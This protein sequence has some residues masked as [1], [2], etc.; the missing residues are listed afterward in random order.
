MDPN[1]NIWLNLIIQIILIF[2]NALFAATEIAVISL[3]KNKLKK[4]ADDGE[5]TAKRLLKLS[6]QPAGFLSTIQIG[7]TLAGFLGSAFAADN[8]SVYLVSFFTNTLHLKISESILR[9]ISV[10]IITLILSYFTLVFGELVPKRIAMQKSYQVA[11]LTS[12]IVYVLSIIMKPVIWL[13]T[14]STNFILK[15]FRLKT[16]SDEEQ[17]TEEEIKMMVDLG[18]ENG[19]IEQAEKRWIKNIF[20]FN[21]TLVRE[22]MTPSRDVKYLHITST[23]KEI[24]DIIKQTG[25]SRLPLVKNDLNDIIGIINIKDYFISDEKNLEKIARKPYFVPETTLADDL[26]R[27]LQKTKNQFA[28]VV[29]E[30]GT[31]TGIITTEDLLEE[32]VGNIYDEYDSKEVEEFIKI[33]D[34]T[35]KVSGNYSIWDLAKNLE[36]E[37]PSDL[38]DFDTVGGLI[39]SCLEEIPNDNTKIVVKKFDL[40]FEVLKMKD[41][42][43]IEVLVKKIINENKIEQKEDDGK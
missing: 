41:R 16:T 5:K 27:N 35:Y 31:T 10:I 43:I 34:L 23:E 9:T 40:S 7:I 42:R 3:N 22:I 13:L 6:E 39:F 37:L 17:V 15:I 12:G 38:K 14:I 1:S 24:E 33:D 4:L 32:I 2:V 19:N 11:K 29:D 8:F 30:Y 20:E 25:V 18:E 21:D 28:V 36:V 26:F